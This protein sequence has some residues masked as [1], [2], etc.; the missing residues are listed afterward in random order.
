MTKQICLL[1]MM[2]QLLLISSYKAHI[3]RHKQ[4][5]NVVYMITVIWYSN[6]TWR[7]LFC[8]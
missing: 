1:P 7:Q 5:I 3:Y 4:L 2:I 8:T 6:F